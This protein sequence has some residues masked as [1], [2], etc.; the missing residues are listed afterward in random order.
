M[1]TI[2]RQFCKLWITTSDTKVNVRQ[3]DVWKGRGSISFCHSRGTKS[4]EATS[5]VRIHQTLVQKSSR[6]EAEC[7]FEL[8][9]FGPRPAVIKLIVQGGNTDK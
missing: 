8:P 4:G 9:Y 1:Y 6:S 5:A 7:A 2:E 3:K